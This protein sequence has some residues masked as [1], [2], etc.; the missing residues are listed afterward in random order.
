MLD[1]AYYILSC[2]CVITWCVLVFY[3]PHKTYS[4]ILKSEV[5]H[6]TQ[7]LYQIFFGVLV[8]YVVGVGI[9]VSEWYEAL[10]AKNVS[11]IVTVC[12]LVS[13]LVFHV[14][15]L[16]RIRKGTLTNIPTHVYAVLVSAL[17]VFSLYQFEKTILIFS[18]TT[19]SIFA[20][21]LIIRYGIHK[22]IKHFL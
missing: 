2:A 19:I 12:I 3:V 11:L 15:T 21:W 13:A 16:I 5:L 7:I 22:Y 20:I 6:F 17:L 1:T 4:N 9:L 8:A 10:M 14:V 18:L